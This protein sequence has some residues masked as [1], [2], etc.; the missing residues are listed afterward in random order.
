[1]GALRTDCQLFRTYAAARGRC[2]PFCTS[3]VE[4]CA[5]DYQGVSHFVLLPAQFV[6]LRLHPTSAFFVLIVV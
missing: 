6:F 2:H 1:M 4:I 5:A 3:F